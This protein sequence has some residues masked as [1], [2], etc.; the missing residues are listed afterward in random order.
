MLQ[1]FF[2]YLVAKPTSKSR[3]TSFQD[4]VYQLKEVTALAVYWRRYSD[5]SSGTGVQFFKSTLSTKSFSFL[6]PFP[7]SL[8]V[9][10]VLSKL[11]SVTPT[12]S[13]CSALS[14]IS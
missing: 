2:S 14:C 3:Q 12:M 9:S 5:V 8:V 13:C 10:F 4:F 6:P 7:G 11:F 1:F